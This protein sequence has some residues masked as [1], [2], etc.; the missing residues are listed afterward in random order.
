MKIRA[1][2]RGGLAEGAFEHPIELGERLETDVVGDFADAPA[3]IHELGFGVFQ[4]DAGDIIG[5]RQARRFL[6]DLAEVEDAGAGGLGD[7]R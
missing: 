1:E 2:L 7:G 3:R 5:K 4:S 6:K